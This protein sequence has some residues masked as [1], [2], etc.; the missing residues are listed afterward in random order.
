MDFGGKSFIPE[1]GWGSTLMAHRDTPL[2]TADAGVKSE[3]WKVSVGI[4]RKESFVREITTEK[5]K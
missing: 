3:E 5:K 1:R 2:H 4:W